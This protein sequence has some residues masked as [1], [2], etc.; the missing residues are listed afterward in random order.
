[1]SG[2]DYYL[3]ENIVEDYQKKPLRLRLKWLYQANKLRKYYSKDIIKKQEKLRAKA[4]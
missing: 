4:G 1:M 3:D 2:F